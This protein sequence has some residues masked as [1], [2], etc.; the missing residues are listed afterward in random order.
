MRRADDRRPGVTAKLGAQ[1]P[2]SSPSRRLDGFL[3]GFSRVTSAG[4]FIPEVD[5]LRFLAIASV[6]VLHVHNVIG[7]EPMT[8]RPKGFADVVAERLASEGHLGVQLFFVISGFILALPFAS[9]WLKGTVRPRLGSYYLRRLTRLEPPYL[10]SLL[11]F[12]AIKVAA[13]GASARA[14]LPPLL[15]SSVYLHNLIYDTPSS[16]SAVAWSLE[17][18]VQFYLLAPLLAMTFAIRPHWLRRALFLAAIVIALALQSREDGRI[19]G[20]ARLVGHNLSIVNSIQY[21]LVGFAIADLYLERDWAKAATTAAWD[22]FAPVAIALLA[23]ADRL[24]L[25]VLPFALPFA[26]ALLFVGA[27]RG[28]MTRNVLRS[29]WIVTIG[30]M[31]Y[32]IYLIHNPTIQLVGALIARLHLVDAHGFARALAVDLAFMAPA[33]LFV[34][35][36]YFRAIERPCMKRDWPSRAAAAVRV[37]LGVAPRRM[38]SP[39]A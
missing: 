10:V 19:A 3:A 32:S 21:F 14:L 2:H 29:R 25:A 20:T 28:S 26:F 12:F 36:A 13:T 38:K 5:G 33:I 18:E 35:A 24:G 34:G 7:T 22:I 17:V 8:S 4:T 39:E 6:V 27:L 31:C 37:W 30:G 16:I 23:F 11:L 15:A 1:P 9:H